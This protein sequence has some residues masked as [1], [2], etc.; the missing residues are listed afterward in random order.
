V[1]AVSAVLAWMGR[2]DVVLAVSILAIVL[3]LVGMAINSTRR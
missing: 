1:A 3:S 2:D